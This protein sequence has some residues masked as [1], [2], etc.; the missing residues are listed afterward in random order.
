MLKLGQVH[1][2][3]RKFQALKESIDINYVDIRHILISNKYY[4]GKKC[5]KCF[6]GYT[7]YYDDNIK[8]LP[9]QVKWI[10]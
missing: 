3:N 9:S 6:I 2:G 5:L 10:N 1:V 7:N 8:C 4:V